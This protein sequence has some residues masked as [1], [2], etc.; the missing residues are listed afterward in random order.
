M[1]L[2][3]ASWKHESML[4]EPQKENTRIGMDR[5]LA[6]VSVQEVKGLFAHCGYRTP[7]QQL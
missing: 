3:R 5:A 6:A 1:T 4:V 2:R 7:A